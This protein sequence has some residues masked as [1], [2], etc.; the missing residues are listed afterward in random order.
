MENVCHLIGLI[1]DSQ[2][3]KKYAETEAY[4]ATRGQNY[5]ITCVVASTGILNSSGSVLLSPAG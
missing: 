1:I 5:V 4:W 3:C 2:I